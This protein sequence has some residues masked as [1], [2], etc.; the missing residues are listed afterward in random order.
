MHKRPQSSLPSDIVANLKGNEQCCLVASTSEATL[1]SKNDDQGK[2]V[3]EGVATQ[4]ECRASA[5]KE[6]VNEGKEICECSLARRYGVVKEEF[7]VFNKDVAKGINKISL[8]KND[9]KIEKM[10]ET[11]KVVTPTRRRK[12]EKESPWNLLGF[13]PPSPFLTAENNLQGLL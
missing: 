4:E 11:S 8:G 13:I 9:D 5:E 6:K 12:K 10:E 3:C 1:K 7:K 2:K